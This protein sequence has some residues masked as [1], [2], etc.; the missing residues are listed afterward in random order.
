MKAELWNLGMNQIDPALLEEHLA[1]KEKYA[2]ANKRRRLIGWTSAAC[3]FLVAL[4]VGLPW[5]MLPRVPNPINPDLPM[6]HILQSS[7][8]PLYYGGS[9]YTGGGGPAGE[10]A[11]DGVSLTARLIETLPDTYTFFDDWDQD[12]YRILYM[13]T[14]KQHKG[15]GATDTFYY[16]VP[17]EFMTDFTPYAYFVMLD[18]AQFGYEYSVL[19]NKTQGC[20]EQL[21]NAPLLAYRSFGYSLMGT[22]LMAFDQTGHF[23]V[24][25]WK[26]TDVWWEHTKDNLPY[27]GLTALYTLQQAE[28]DARP[29]AEYPYRTFVHTVQGLTGEAAELMERLRSVDDGLYVQDFATGHARGDYG[30]SLHYTRYIDGFPTNEKISISSKSGS[31]TEPNACRTS[32]AQFTAEDLTKLPDLRTAVNTVEAA[33][34]AG[35]IKPPHFAYPTY[36]KRTLYGICGWYAKTDSGVIG[37]VRVTFCLQCERIPDRPDH[38]FG[39]G[40]YDDAY[41]ILE[42]GDDTCRPIDR[43]A[44]LSMF[45]EYETTNIYTGDYCDLGKDLPE[46]PYA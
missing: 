11:V 32:K 12:E 40:H 42:Y 29:P 24:G 33:C 15:E 26:S 28:R 37:I 8:E 2:K 17:V 14:V 5:V 35:K 39:G 38:K 41:Y 25:L 30:V 21:D 9:S 6:T 31:G 1:Q 36:I 10:E 4:A 19:Y 43:D 27:L 3:A 20:A 18:A 46:Q 23:D 7:N 16:L 44:L 45:G 13:Q 22:N 34:E